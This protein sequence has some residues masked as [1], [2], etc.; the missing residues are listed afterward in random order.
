MGEDF[1]KAE[2]EGESDSSSEPTVRGGLE[3]DDTISGTASLWYEEGNGSILRID[4]V[5]GVER[6]SESLNSG[7]SS[8]GFEKS[9]KAS[10][11]NRG[12]GNT[13]ILASLQHTFTSYAEPSEEMC[14]TPISHDAGIRGNDLIV[15]EQTLSDSSD[16]SF[17]AA[18]EVDAFEIPETVNVLFRQTGLLNSLSERLSEAVRTGLGSIMVTSLERGE[19]KTS[20]AIGLAIAGAASGIKVALVDANLTEPSLIDSLNLEV[21]H[22]WDAHSTGVPMSE[23]AIHSIADDLTLFPLINQGACIEISDGVRERFIT[24]LSDHFD[25][26]IF[27]GGTCSDLDLTDKTHFLNADSAVIVRDLSRSNESEV[28]VCARKIL[29]AGVKSVGIVE[30]HAS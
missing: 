23:I 11:E 10:G 2:L 7:Q 13:E 22:G 14:R 1:A 12:P 3:L 26:I 17:S 21:L 30:N 8:D 5:N 29:E 24:L 4:P 28:S 27:D 15:A 18:W 19:G 20:V 6:L 25:L 9:D 16:G